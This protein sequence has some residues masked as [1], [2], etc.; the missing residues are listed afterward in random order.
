[1][2]KYTLQIS[3]DNSPIDFSKHGKNPAEQIEITENFEELKACDVV[4]C[5]KGIFTQNK[6]SEYK[7]YEG[8]YEQKI[9][10][11]KNNIPILVHDVG[12]H[13][14]DEAKSKIGLFYVNEG[15]ICEA[16]E[17]AH[18]DI[19]ESGQPIEMNRL[20]ML[21][22]EP[23]YLL[24]INTDKRYNQKNICYVSGKADKNGIF[25]ADISNEK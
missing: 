18:V 2:P 19:V 10:N 9:E 3:K 12:I 14:S 11:L 8:F 21:D 22:K 6:Y 1:M 13:G 23:T 25:N 7:K 17:I 4:E 15:K 24:F 20:Y 16:A 5:L